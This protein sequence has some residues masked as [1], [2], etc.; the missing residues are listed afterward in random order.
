MTANS[1]VI[2]LTG[3]IAT[4]KSTVLEYL[5]RLG[6]YIIDADK[7][8]HQA[9]TPEGPAYQ[10]VIG[11]FGSAILNADKTVNRKALGSI[12]FKNADL[13]N[14]LEQIVH[15][16]VFDMTL[17]LV[18]ASPSSVIVLEAVKLL[19]AGP[20]FSQC[21]EVW[22]VTARPE[23]QLRRLM[24]T[25]GMD[26]PTARQR[27]GMQSPQAAKINQAD[28]VIDNSGTLEELYAQLDEIWAALKVA[29][30]RRMA[31]LSIPAAVELNQAGATP[32][33]HNAGVNT[34]AS[35]G[36]ERSHP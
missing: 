3:N 22:V 9:L 1:L 13:L 8:A 19:E 25:R 6:A 31:R 33:D 17:K 32:A 24:E 12:V 16:A 30:P 5:A 4:G 34:G 20:M 7:L 35:N 27:M 29:Y 18:E 28:R 15:P 11:E 21:D 14:K 23:V 26:E 36:G 10:A 2:G